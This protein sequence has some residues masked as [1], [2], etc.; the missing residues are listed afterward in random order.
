MPGA[1]CHDG[2]RTDPRVDLSRQDVRD[3]QPRSEVGEFG[4]GP[5]VAY[6]AELSR[7]EQFRILYEYKKYS[8]HRPSDARVPD[9]K[10]LGRDWA[11]EEGD[12]A[13]RVARVD[14]DKLVAVGHHAALRRERH[15][16]FA[17]GQ[18]FKVG[19]GDRRP[20]QVAHVAMH[21]VPRSNQ[22]CTLQ[23]TFTMWNSG[24]C[25]HYE[26]V[27][28]TPYTVAGPGPFSRPRPLSWPRRT[29]GPLVRS[30]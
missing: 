27:L 30:H 14:H 21:N 25:A 11:V 22:G 24:T 4:S 10:L 19:A 26:V 20:W 3:D 7:L 5:R 2:Q 1:P 16:A 28:R 18:T 23:P 9:N 13:A 8:I 17:C 6:M 12:D 29:T 15:H